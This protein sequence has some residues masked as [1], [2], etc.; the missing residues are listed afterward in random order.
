[1]QTMIQYLPGLKRSWSGHRRASAHHSRT[2]SRVYACSESHSWTIIC[3][4]ASSRA[5]RRN[6]SVTGIG[7]V[8]H[9]FKPKEVLTCK[10]T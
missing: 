3:S 1:M 5:W 8:I 7:S 9:I 2:G 6:K 4:L 10:P